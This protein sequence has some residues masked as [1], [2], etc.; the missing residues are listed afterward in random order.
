MG[1]TIAIEAAKAIGI[2]NRNR[3]HQGPGQ[4]VSNTN[5]ESITPDT[6]R[7]I[8]SDTSAFV[9]AVPK[10]KNRFHK[11]NLYGNVSTDERTD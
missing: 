10:K 7:V 4:A 2:K 9:E 3:V 6:N 1:N 5:Q 11:K 8:P